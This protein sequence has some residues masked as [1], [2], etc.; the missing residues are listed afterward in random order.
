[1]NVYTYPIDTRG[2]D[3]LIPSQIG[4]ARSRLVG[5]P[6]RKSASCRGRASA[7]LGLRIVSTASRYMAA[8]LRQQPIGISQ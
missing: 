1:M 7:E 4:K 3:I 6:G 5:K 8:A 2:L